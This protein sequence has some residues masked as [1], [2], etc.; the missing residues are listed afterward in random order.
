MDEL[1]KAILDRDA[2]E[3]GEDIEKAYKRY[4]V[5]IGITDWIIIPDRFIFSVKLKGET[6]EAHVRARVSDVQ[7]RLKLPLFQVVKSDF[8]IYIVAS[9]QKVVYQHL[10]EILSDSDCVKFGRKLCLPYV[11]GHDVTGSI[12]MVDLVQF[13]HLLMAGASNSGKTVGLRSLLVNLVFM[14]SPQRLNLILIDVGAADLI[15]FNGIPHLSCPVVS[16]RDMACQVLVLLTTEME[17]RVK[18]QAT[19]NDQFKLLPRLVLAIDEFPALFMGM[20]DRQTTKLIANAISNLLQRGRHAKIHVVLAAQNP[21]IQNMKVDLGN[22][23]ARIAFKCAKKNFSET[24]LGESGAE[25]LMGQGDMYFRYPQYEGLRRIQ[26]IFISQKELWQV[27]FEIKRE[28]EFRHYDD[29]LKFIINETSLQKIKKDI[30]CNPTER[31]LTRKTDVDDK[32][33]ADILLW[34]LRQKTISCNLIMK[35]FNIGWKRADS[36]VERLNNL[37]IVENLDTKLPRKVLTYS[38]AEIPE[39]VIELLKR[40]GHSVE[41]VSDAICNK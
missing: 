5:N 40:N 13:P 20:E 11:V 9:R 32:M 6:R 31:S 17:R 21:T 39:E 34:T 14:K 27:L 30:I 8:N 41:T 2:E 26:G 4:R 18:L 19:N 23:T 28:F 1:E 37:G 38:I 29:K 15:P 24:I 33:F 3:L 7:Q 16:D 35:N 22:I 10:P 25:N 12:V 36:F